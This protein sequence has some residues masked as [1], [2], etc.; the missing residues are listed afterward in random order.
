[1]ELSGLGVDEVRGERAGISPKE[2][3]RERAVAP[4]EPGEVEPDEQLRSGVEQLVA[5]VRDAA[6]C[7]ERAKR[8]RVVEVP[9]DEDRLQVVASSSRNPDDLDDGHL[10][11]LEGPKQAVLAPGERLRNLLQRVQRA[12]VLDEAHDVPADATHDLDETLGR[13]VASG[14]SHGRSRKLGCPGRA[15][16]RSRGA[17]VLT[18]RSS[19]SDDGDAPINATLAMSARLDHGNDGRAR[20]PARRLVPCVPGLA[21]DRARRLH[22]AAREVL[23]PLVEQADQRRAVR[24]LRADL[25][26]ADAL[27]L[28]V[29]DAVDAALPLLAGGELDRLIDA[30]RRPSSWRS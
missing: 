3:V 18:R 1:M 24:R 19:A 5:Q 20:G 9:R 7:E 21:G 30:R 2:R 29:E 6:A 27:V 25:A 12:V 28:D 16:S 15:T 11:L 4:E 10:L 26:V 17:V 14:L 22:L 8:Q 13:P 23:R